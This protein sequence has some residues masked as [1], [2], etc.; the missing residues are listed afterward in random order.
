MVKDDSDDSEVEHS[1]KGKVNAK[2]K[3]RSPID[4]AE[5]VDEEDDGDEEEEEED[6]EDSE[7]EEEARE[8]M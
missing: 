2:L 4:D 8:N 3:A 7:D 1:N 5:E 6:E